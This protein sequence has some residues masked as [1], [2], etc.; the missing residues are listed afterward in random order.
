M[1]LLPSSVC[2]YVLYKNSY[3]FHLLQQVPLH[4][5]RT[6]HS[7]IL[8][9]GYLKCMYHNIEEP[10]SSFHLLQAPLPP[11]TPHFTHWW[12]GRCGSFPAVGQS[13]L[14]RGHHRVLHPQHAGVPDSL[15]PSPL[16]ERPQ[17]PRRGIGTPWHRYYHGQ[18][19]IWA[20]HLLTRREVNE[21]HPS[22]LSP[23]PRRRYCCYGR[24]RIYMSYIRIF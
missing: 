2:I 22:L 4:H 8:C 7:Y 12:K 17:A 21:R 9:H 10:L 14:G 13:A 24:W 23:G 6:P 19:R 1:S 5:Q 15:G 16:S 3:P 18:W 20:T 11:P